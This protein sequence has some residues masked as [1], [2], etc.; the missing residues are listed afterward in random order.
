[1]VIGK[2]KKIIFKNKKKSFFYEI[3]YEKKETKIKL[4]HA[5]VDSPPSFGLPS[6][7]TLF[8]PSIV[9]DT[10]FPRNFDLGR[11]SPRMATWFAGEM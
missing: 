7:Y 3:S 1:M 8:S 6:K 5:T 11:S 10:L 9:V 2:K 4:N